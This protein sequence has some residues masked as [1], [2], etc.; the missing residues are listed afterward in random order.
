MTGTAKGSRARSRCVRTR[1][2]EHRLV[3][4]DSCSCGIVHVHFG[5]T[6]LRLEPAAAAEICRSLAL[7]LKR[8]GGASDASS[9][10]LFALDEPER[11]V[12]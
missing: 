9:G 8:M 11:G 4:I 10:L 5:A 2:C 6:T 3:Q 7:A 1:L 12:A